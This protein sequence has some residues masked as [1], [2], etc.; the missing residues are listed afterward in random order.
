MENTTL[1]DFDGKAL[2]VLDMLRENAPKKSYVITEYADGVLKS[3]KI[4]DKYDKTAS[5]LW[6]GDEI[7]SLY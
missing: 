6:D 1:F 2:P 5:Y 3:V 4:A 7:K